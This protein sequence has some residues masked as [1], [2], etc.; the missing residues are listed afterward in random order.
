MNI[1]SFYSHYLAV[2]TGFALLLLALLLKYRTSPTAFALMGL[3]GVAAG[4]NIS[5]ILCMNSQD[6]Q[7]A[8][9]WHGNVRLAFNAFTVPTGFAFVYTFLNGRNKAVLWFAFG[10]P[11]LTVL[12]S[13]T[14]H[15]HQAM[16]SSYTMREM[17]G[18]YLRE[19]WKPG[20]WF[21]L[22]LVYSCL[23]SLVVFYSLF[24]WVNKTHQLPRWRG[25]LI[26]SVVIITFLCVT[27]D[28]LGISIAPG[29]LNLPL[30]LGLIM[31]GLIISVWYLHLF[32]VLPVAREAIIRYMSDGVFVVDT[33]NQVLDA[34][35]AALQLLGL[36][37]LSVI[38]RSIVEF[39]T[40][41]ERAAETSE[42]LRGE[43]RVVRPFTVDGVEHFLDMMATNISP[44]RGV[45]TARLIVVRDVSEL[46]KLQ[47][48]D[49]LRSALEERQ[50]LARDLHDAVSQTLFS[51]R[52]ASEMLL[53]QKETIQPIVLWQNIEMIAGL[54]KGALG[55][56]RILL[57]ELRPES[58]VNAALPVL[59]NHLA[60]AAVSR[61]D[62]QI[63]INARSNIALPADVKI[64]LYRIAQE[65]LNNSI[66]HAH[67]TEINIQLSNEDDVVKLS[68]QDNGVGLGLWVPGSG[69]GLKIMHE[70]AAEVGANLEINSTTGQ[71]TQVVC[72]VTTGVTHG[73][74]TH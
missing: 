26:L 65:A 74:E 40:P 62:A 18:Y 17:A 4:V 3:A 41:P 53:L 64:A 15:W 54:V 44:E 1:Y 52:L 61:T 59:L 49:V 21:N 25:L 37:L 50:R 13:I 31:L 55:E 36:P 5:L 28:T 8:A 12:V 38:G 19:S 20:I 7:A 69:L 27:L 10:V 68:I 73:Y 29:I 9:F 70:R 11:I 67:C 63:T 22:Y 66:K 14:N 39:V 57:L 30:G 42:L 6:I 56:M 47:A 23:I 43:F 58:L 71:G 45:V 24:Q 33:E 46:K 60:D 2:S 32:D 34:N 16:F 51:A 72:W 48:Q 35:P